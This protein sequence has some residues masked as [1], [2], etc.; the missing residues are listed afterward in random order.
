VQVWRDIAENLDE[1]K[2]TAISEKVRAR[3]AAF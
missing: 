2:I 3:V 1:S